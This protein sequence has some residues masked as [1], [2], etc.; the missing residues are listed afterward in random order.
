MP[1][2]T[3]HYNK[4]YFNKLFSNS[5]SVIVDL[6]Y[7]SDNMIM[8]K[9]L[10]N[11][12]LPYKTEYSFL[13]MSSTYYPGLFYFYKK[14]KRGKKNKNYFKGKVV[15][16]VDN[17]VMSSFEHLSL[18]FQSRPNTI[19][20]GCHTAGANGPVQSF[21]LPGGFKATISTKGV[22][23]P[24]KSQLQRKGV[25]VD[26]SVCPTIYG[27]INEQDELLNEARRIALE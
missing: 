1:C 25:R 16:I 20:I 2:A 6:R 15:V 22:Y 3:K 19:V 18:A 11:H 27:L 8:W 14:Q 5:K 13:T 24:D 23:Y 26:F 9:I 12:L 4:K 7:F 17:S 10:D 21:S